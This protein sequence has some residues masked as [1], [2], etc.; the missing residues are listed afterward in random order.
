M[1]IDELIY[2]M[3]RGSS[4]RH[5]II[6]RRRLEP[7]LHQVRFA[8]FRVPIE[9]QESDTVR[10]FTGRARGRMR[11]ANLNGVSDGMEFRF[12]DS[13]VEA[14]VKPKVGGWVLEVMD[15]ENDTSLL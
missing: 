5:P 7:G 9:V 15:F 3:S 12:M 10:V 13:L 11:D 6:S 14:V 2:D 1:S 8:G 4:G